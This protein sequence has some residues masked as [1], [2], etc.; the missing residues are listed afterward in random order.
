M[1]NFNKLYNE[2][3]KEILK[4][5]ELIDEVN[6]R[7]RTQFVKEEGLNKSI[8]FDG[9]LNRGEFVYNKDGKYWS[10]KSRG[11]EEERWSNS[12]LRILCI[13]KDSNEGV[14]EDSDSDDSGWD[15]RCESGRNNGSEE[16]KITATF[17]KNYMAVVSLI[18]SCC[19]C[20]LAPNMPLEVNNTELCRC[21][22]EEI[23]LARI[24]LKKQ[25]GGGSISKSLLASY[26]TF[27]KEVLIKQI[28]SLNAN[29]II[30]TSAV[31]MNLLKEIYDLE[32]VN[33]EHLGTKRDWVYVAPKNN[34]TVI[35]SYHF[36]CWTRWVEKFQKYFYLYYANRYQYGMD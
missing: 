31:G 36:S 7:K 16:I 29:V 2:R 1:E 8:C 25:P 21:I 34:I 26:A 20:A 30:C 10:R 6:K 3:T 27:Y 17:Y 18:S 9:I 11:D 5:S 15:I 19:Q 4:H 12:K 32:R 14:G 13:T 35:N 24:N 23:P 33:A 22:W 28:K